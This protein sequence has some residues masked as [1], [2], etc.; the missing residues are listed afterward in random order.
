MTLAFRQDV[1]CSIVHGRAII[2]DLETDRYS[3]P[4]STACC[5]LAEI[6]ADRPD[7]IPE[8]QELRPLVECGLLVPCRCGEPGKDFVRWAAPS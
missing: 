6:E 5:V 3:S 7:A 1:F 8:C 2:L 4:S